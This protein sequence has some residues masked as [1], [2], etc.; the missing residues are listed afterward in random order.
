MKEV[1]FNQKDFNK[2]EEQYFRNIMHNKDMA[3]ERIEERLKKRKIIPIWIYYAAASIF[4]VFG[5]SIFY[6]Q[7]LNR[8]N[9]EIAQ[10]KLKFETQKFDTINTEVFKHQHNNIDTVKIVQEKIVQIPVNLRDTLII[11]DTISKI[12]VQKDTIFIKEKNTGHKNENKVLVSNNV[13]E[14]QVI[15]GNNVKKKREKRFIIRFGKPKIESSDKEEPSLFTL[16]TK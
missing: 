8:K 2:A 11:Y 4:L 14:N 10:L 16:R 7:S 3:W 13:L 15:E 1:Q 9:Q 12:M 6:S 5:I